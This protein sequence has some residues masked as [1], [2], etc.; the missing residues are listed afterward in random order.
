MREGLTEKLGE[1]KRESDRE[2]KRGAENRTER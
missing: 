2:T 1:V